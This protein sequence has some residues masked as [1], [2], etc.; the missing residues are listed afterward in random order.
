MDVRFP[1]WNNWRVTPA[2]LK[3][4]VI[5]PFA[6]LRVVRLDRDAIFLYKTYPLRATDIDDL[7]TILTNGA[8][9]Q[10]RV[11]DLFDEQDGIHRSELP[12]DTTHEP[13]FNILE[14]RVRFA[15]SLQLLGP[16]RRKEIP[17]IA[18][19]ATRRFQDLHLHRSLE[20]LIDILRTSELVS[21]DNIV[22]T[23]FGPLRN[24]LAASPR[25]Q[26]GSNRQR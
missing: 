18:R 21:W 14:L 11:I 1:T 2:L 25:K 22:G 3:R 6:K 5:L 15:A 7:K 20:D 13:L 19:H 23:G 26:S 10:S 24:R 17:H 12:E 8:P 16:L 4:A 9:D